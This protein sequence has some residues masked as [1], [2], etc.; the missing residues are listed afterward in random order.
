MA[1]QNKDLLN[2]LLTL[3]RQDWGVLPPA[4]WQ[5]L[6]TC[7]LPLSW[8]LYQQQQNLDQALLV[9]IN[10]PQGCGKSTTVACLQTLLQRYFGLR[11]AVVSIDD[12]YLTQAERQALAA[13]RH[14]LLKTRGVPGTHDVQLAQTTL[15]RLVK[16]KKVAVKVPYFNKAIDD[17]S[18]EADWPSYQTPIDVILFEGWCVGATPQAE[19]EL[20]QP[21]NE[22]ERD[23]DANGAWRQYVNQSLQHDYRALFAKLDCLLF[24]SCGDFSWVYQ[25][26]KQ[27]EQ[28]NARRA[29]ASGSSL[30]G[31]MND[32]QLKRFV[33]HYERVTRHCQKILPGLAD[34]II[35]LNYSREVTALQWRQA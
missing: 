2:Q 27:Q 33:L 32:Q 14:P 11:V 35:P 18:P 26:R 17:R 15:D 13:Q 19:A 10:G 7:E 5:R 21:V 1:K 31:I 29:Q 30:I 34:V 25:W 6:A 3:V 28:E 16:E 8:W 4:L 20:Q 23:E 9:G 24:F 12:F 22:L